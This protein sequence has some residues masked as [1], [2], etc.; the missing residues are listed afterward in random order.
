MS[1]Q[2]NIE[3]SGKL[4]AQST[5]D[6]MIKMKVYLKFSA[7]LCSIESDYQL[8]NNTNLNLTIMVQTYTSSEHDLLTLIILG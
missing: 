3:E 5:E 8:I 4:V 2:Q 6:E 7:G 1:K